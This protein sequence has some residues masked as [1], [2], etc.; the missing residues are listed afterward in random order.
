MNERKQI[1]FHH[2][3]GRDGAMPRR[4]IREFLRHRAHQPFDFTLTFCEVLPP[5]EEAVY[6]KS[7]TDRRP[8]CTGARSDRRPDAV[9]A[10]PDYS[11]ARAL[12][13]F[14]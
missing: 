13:C 10:Q 3:A 9:R 4:I 14:W 12:A 5:S 1:Q 11:I 8:A 6:E 2:R 7:R